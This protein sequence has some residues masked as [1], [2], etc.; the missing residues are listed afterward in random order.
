MSDSEP[1]RKPNLAATS[2]AL[3]GLLSY[4]QELSGYDI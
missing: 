4:E 1:E 2:W 3:L